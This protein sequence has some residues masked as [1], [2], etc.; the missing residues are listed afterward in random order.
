[1]NHRPQE[2]SRP[3]YQELEQQL[4]EAHQLIAAL[5]SGEADAIITELEVA[6]LHARKIEAAL[7]QSEENFRH[8]LEESPLGIR[9]VNAEGETLYANPALL[10]ICGCNSIEEFAASPR[11][12][13]Y[14]PESYAEHRERVEKR[15]RSEHVPSHYEESV[16][17]KG[18]EIRHLEVFRK[19]V[20]WD[21][22]RQF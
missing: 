8:S 16:V 6:L 10:A 14:T 19:E 12:E 9:I 3:T 5:R 18:G 15:Q 11:K 7:R 20:L 21:G 1:M 22:K 13:R 4:A 17:R 2:S